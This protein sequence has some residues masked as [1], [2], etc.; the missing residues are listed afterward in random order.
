[1]ETQV[2]KMAAFTLIFQLQALIFQVLQYQILV[3]KSKVILQWILLKY[4]VTGWLMIKIP[5]IIA[6]AIKSKIKLWEMDA[7][8]SWALD[9]AIL[10]FSLSLLIV[11]KNCNNILLA[12]GIMEI[13]GLL[14]HQLNVHL[15]GQILLIFS[16]LPKVMLWKILFH[17]M[18]YKWSNDTTKSYKMINT[19]LL[20]ISR[21]FGF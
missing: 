10:M 7:T 2:V 1:M 15:L 13:N 12:G 17:R 20:D 19:R 9:G 5:L 16:E 21:F 14:N 11:H 6:I 4:V 3:I 18:I 8:T